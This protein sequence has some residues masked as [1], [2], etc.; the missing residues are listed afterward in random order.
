[1]ITLILFIFSLKSG[2]AQN[3]NVVF[4]DSS[5]V[6]YFYKLKPGRDRK[7]SIRVEF[8]L[9]ALRDSIEIK[10]FITPLWFLV[11]TTVNDFFILNTTIGQHKFYNRQPRFLPLNPK[12]KTNADVYILTSYVSVNT[13][14]AILQEELETI[15]F[16]FSPNLEAETYFKKYA[17]NREL[18][19]YERYCIKLSK[20]TLHSKVSKPSESQ[21]QSLKIWVNSQIKL[22][23]LNGSTQH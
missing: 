8:S 6:L 14:N 4:N 5:K 23:S 20:R 11:S 19:E 17:K 7:D 12:L 9:D 10:T 1:M 22:R 18:S 2:L 3:D 21:L 15:Y 16:Y 13:L